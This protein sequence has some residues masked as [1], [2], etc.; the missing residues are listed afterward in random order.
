MQ[1]LELHFR[2]KD[3]P[4]V[5]Y[6]S[7]CYEPEN[8]SEQRLGSLYIVG[9]LS[10]TEGQNRYFLDNLSGAIKTKYYG[11]TSRSPAAA[12]R[13]SL[14]TANKVLAELVREGNV[15]WLGNLDYA[16]LSLKQSDVEQKNPFLFSFTRLG[17]I[18]VFLMRGK[19]MVEIGTELEAQ[20]IEPY[21]LKVFFNIAS[22]KLK[23]NDRLL[24][25]SQ[26][27]FEQ[28]P[29]LI[30]KIAGLPSFE[31]KY[32]NSIFRAHN[33]EP[34][35]LSGICFIVVLNKEKT[36]PTAFTFKEKPQRLKTLKPI[37]Q[38]IL[39]KA[40]IVK[41]TLLSLKAKLAYRSKRKAAK[42]KKQDQEAK[43]WN[44]RFLL[45]KK[46]I[47][48]LLLSL[49][50]LVGFV[51]FQ[52]E[53][54]R[55]AEER[56]AVLQKAQEKI[57]QAQ[58]LLFLKE[59]EKANLI[60]QEAWNLVL[61]QTKNGA[62][63]SDQASRLQETIEKELAPLNALQII[64][65][66]DVLFEI[67]PTELGVVPQKMLF[68]N[69]LDG[70]PELYIFNPASKNFYRFNLK[71]KIGQATSSPQNLN[72][73]ASFQDILFFLSG[74][75]ILSP[76]GRGWSSQGLGPPYDHV[77]YNDMAVSSLNGVVYIYCLDSQAGQIVKYVSEKR[78][79][80]WG[81]PQLWLKNQAEQTRTLQAKSIAVDNSIWLL[82]KDGAIEHYYAGAFQGAIK[83]NIFPFLEKPTKVWTSI[84]DRRLYVLEPDKNR[85][86]ML[87][88]TGEVIKQY[89]SQSFDNLLDF[90]ISEDGKTIWLL[91]G[92]EVYQIA[93]NTSD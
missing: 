37:L 75:N 50:L 71:N 68:Y 80:S 84:Y 43:Q 34:R 5:L 92:S 78:A 14:K 81:K 24:V 62:L 52:Q 77:D 10:K 11:L 76:Q 13:E 53:K 42:E 19:T 21:P 23:E 69:N 89:Q 83:I 49:F 48:V 3:D 44:F 27:L 2:A 91:N 79:S 38:T 20:D 7:F 46:V 28:N 58:N 31:T 25:V 18:K 85:L 8:S 55:S 30:E 74:L 86:V 61:P 35:E 60:L 39:Q 67:K 65:N 16:I 1:V 40:A 26:A 66:P 51:I 64:E 87:S 47:Y 82:D 6:D 9:E 22:A 72:L 93:A 41:L 29:G 88:K 45:N 36:I 63:L 59:T 12:L 70:E 54:K 15:N 56:Q 4:D 17:K 32:F 73:G 90:A 33:K 57:D